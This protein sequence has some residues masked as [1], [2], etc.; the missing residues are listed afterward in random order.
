MLATAFETMRDLLNLN[1]NGTQDSSVEIWVT[2]SRSVL[3]WRLSSTMDAEFRVAALEE[4]INRYGVPEIFNRDRGVQF[5]S[6]E[7]TQALKDARGA[8][9]M[10]GKGR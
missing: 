9:S 10:D 6:Q 4:A 2:I 7:F 3:A 1:V 8:I 5:S